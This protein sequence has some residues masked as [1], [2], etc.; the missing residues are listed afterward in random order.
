ME[1]VRVYSLFNRRALVTRGA[2][3]VLRHN[4]LAAGHRGE[5]LAL[6]LSGIDAITPSFLDQLLFVVEESLP[7]GAPPVKLLMLNSPPGF[8]DRMESIGRYHHLKVVSDA[9]GDW[10]VPADSPFP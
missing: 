4:V 3:G 5:P 6:D 1:V 10:L 8:R 7:S 9:Q 2:A